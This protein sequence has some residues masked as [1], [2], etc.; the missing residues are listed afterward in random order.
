MWQ[1]DII[2]MLAIL[3]EQ[4]VTSGLFPF[5]WFINIIPYSSKD[6]KTIA[7]RKHDYSIFRN[8]FLVESLRRVS[9][10]DKVPPAPLIELRDIKYLFQWLCKY[11]RKYIKRFGVCSE[12]IYYVFSKRIYST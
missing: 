4:T 12:I 3:V 6:P 1:P 8:D 2:Q 9:S 5:G 7:I 10:K 11:I